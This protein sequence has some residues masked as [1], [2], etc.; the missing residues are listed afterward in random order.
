MTKPKSRQSRLHKVQSV[1]ELDYSHIVKAR[2]IFDPYSLIFEWGPTLIKTARAIR[3]KRAVS[4]R[5]FKVGAANIAINAV[6]MKAASFVGANYTPHQGAPKRCAEMQAWRHALRADYIS[7]IGLFVAGSTDP[8]E[9]EGVTGLATPTLHLC[10]PCLGDIDESTVIVSLGYK[11]DKYESH[12]G[13]EL[14]NFYG[15]TNKFIGTEHQA[16]IDPDFQRFSAAR[17]IY[18][19][20]VSSEGYLGV[21]EGY[22]RMLRA[23]AVVQAIRQSAAA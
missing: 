3:A 22:T 23:E 19:T 7:P 21:N 11:E 12:T 4:Y 20:I 2:E 1:Q 14:W 13:K 18:K 10:K 15:T 6:E 5:G 9:V 16:I 17:G 8:K